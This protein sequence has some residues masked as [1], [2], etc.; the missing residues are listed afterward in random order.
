MFALTPGCTKEMVLL[1]LGQESAERGN[2]TSPEL[3]SKGPLLCPSTPVPEAQPSPDR[4]LPRLRGA[5][6][7]GL[8]PLGIF[9]KANMPTP[10]R[11]PAAR[12]TGGRRRGPPREVRGRGAVRAAG[13]PPRWN[14]RRAA[15]LASPAPAPS[16]FVS[17]EPAGAPHGPPSRQG[18]PSPGALSGGREG[19]SSRGSCPRGAGRP[20]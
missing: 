12:K 15:G 14:P 2:E 11:S 1:Q 4:I 13:S 6:R 19:C 8:R 9:L 17:S 3:G 16:R 20:P 18:Q 10:I 7:R 5:L